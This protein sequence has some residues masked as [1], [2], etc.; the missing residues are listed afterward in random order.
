MK[1]SLKTS[2]NELSPK[3]ILDVATGSGSFIKWTLKVLDD[4]QEI[5]GIDESDAA[6]TRAKKEFHQK[7]IS[8]Q[9]MN[10]AELTFGDA[11]FDLVIISNSLHHLSNVPH[12]LA[13]AKRVLRLS[14][15]IISEF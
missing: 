12:S 15:G 2:M 14:G 3:R 8:F 4:F 7:N 1:R 10:S 9:K 6:I 5:I 11:T 13:E